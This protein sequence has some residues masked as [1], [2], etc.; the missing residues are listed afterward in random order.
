MQL[1]LPPFQAESRLK[2][3]I[4]ATLTVA[5]T[6]ITFYICYVPVIAYSV[7]RNNTENVQE[8]SWVSFLV[9]FSTFI[10]SASNPII[11][12]LRNKRYRSAV[13]QLVKDPLGSSPFQEMPFRGDKKKK[14]RPGNDTGM[15]ERETPETLRGYENAV[16]KEMVLTDKKVYKIAW[17]E[18]E[19]ESCCNQACKNELN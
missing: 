5:I 3:D 17:K 16:T 12:V 6:V 15:K 8:H 11:Y 2:Q 14:S 18:V 9:S 4:K 13:R 19:E 10:S 1:N 7:W